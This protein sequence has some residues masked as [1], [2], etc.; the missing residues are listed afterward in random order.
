MT[1]VVSKLAA[2]ADRLADWVFAARTWRARRE[3]RARW[4]IDPHAVPPPHVL[5]A[6][7]RDIYTPPRDE[8]GWKGAPQYAATAG[9]P[10][11]GRTPDPPATTAI[12]C[13][14]PGVRPHPRT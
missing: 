10:D 7:L 3:L 11:R 12:A 2:V 5:D 9:T 6:I 14:C 13:R 8:D 1:A 4:G